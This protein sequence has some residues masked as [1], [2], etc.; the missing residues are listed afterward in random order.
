MGILDLMRL[1]EHF[2]TLSLKD[3][4]KV[5]TAPGKNNE[6]WALDSGLHITPITSVLELLATEEWH[7]NSK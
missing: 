7:S 3:D 5:E 2:T 4:T 1:E 6:L